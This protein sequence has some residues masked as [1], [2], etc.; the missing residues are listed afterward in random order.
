MSIVFLLFSFILVKYQLALHN[1]RTKFRP[2][3][4]FNFWCIFPTNRCT[5][6]LLILSRL[7]TADRFYEE[8]LFLMRN[9]LRELALPAEGRP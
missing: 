7:R 6:S 4:F 9:T 8:L 1:C 2:N 5:H 3:F